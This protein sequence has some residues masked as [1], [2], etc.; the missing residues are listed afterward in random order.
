MPGVTAPIKPPQQSRDRVRYLLLLAADS[1]QGAARALGIHPRTMR[2]YCRHGALPLCM[3]YA[4]RGLIAE[5][6]G[7]R[8]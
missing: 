7:M 3:D 2:R 8:V 4:L 5:R 1:Q 6:H